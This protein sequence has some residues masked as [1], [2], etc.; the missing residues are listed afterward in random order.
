[1][2]YMDYFNKTVEYFDN[3]NFSKEEFLSGKWT[4]AVFTAVQLYLQTL[5]ECEAALDFK[6]CSF[7]EDNT[8]CL[9]QYEGDGSMKINEYLENKLIAL[10]VSV[11]ELKE[12]FGDKITD[13]FSLSVVH[14][15]TDN[16]GAQHNSRVKQRYC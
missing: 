16:H 5:G 12:I 1:M 11:Y 15:W 14:S 8:F 4:P 10:N 2:T 7:I 6:Q 13:A 9:T 3:P